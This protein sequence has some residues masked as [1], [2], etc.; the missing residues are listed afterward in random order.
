MKDTTD[1]RCGRVL[2]GP[3]GRQPHIA[4]FDAQFQCQLNRNNAYN[5]LGTSHPI[6]DVHRVAVS[7]QGKSSVRYS[8]QE[9]FL[10]DKSFI[11]HAGGLDLSLF[12][13]STRQHASLG[14]STI[15]ISNRRIN[16][17]PCLSCTSSSVK[18][19]AFLCPLQVKAPHHSSLHQV[20]LSGIMKNHIGMDSWRMSNSIPVW[21]WKWLETAYQVPGSK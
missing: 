12:C 20:A 15:K 14:H 1:Y 3:P 4:D 13:R 8:T 17:Q 16:M 6:E 11:M 5:S 19:W 7:P 9:G 21:P 2:T 10:C 18:W